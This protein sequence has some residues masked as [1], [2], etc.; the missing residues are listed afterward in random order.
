MSQVPFAC[1]QGGIPVLFERLRN[2]DTV[3]IQITLIGW[4][5]VSFGLLGWGQGHMA[6]PRLVWMIACHQRGTRRTTT[7][8]VVELREAN[9][10][11]SQSVNVG[12][13]DLAAVITKIGKPH[14]IDHDQDDIGAFGSSERTWQQEWQQK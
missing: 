12:R 10:S 13:L 2:G 7:A 1:H 11:V 14:V 5:P 6:D 3:L 4:R 8:A 9:P